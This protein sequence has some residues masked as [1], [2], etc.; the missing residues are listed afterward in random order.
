MADQAL[1]E[2][3]F[4]TVREL[5]DLLRLKER[6]VYDLA[7]S[8]AVPC[9]RATGKLLFPAAEIR[10]WIAREKSGGPA[11]SAER[12]GIALG[13]HDPLLDWAILESRCGLATY[14]DGS[15]DGLDRFVK[16]EG[17]LTGLHIFDAKSASWNVPAVAQAAAGQAAVLVSFVKR[18]RGLILR[19]DGPHPETLAELAGL[20]VA[21]R[22]DGSGT[23]GLLHA[24]AAEHG[25]DLAAVTFTDTARTEDEAA[26]SVRRGDADTTLG[27]ETVAM[28]F[29]L[30]FVPLIE[31]EFSL[32]V[33]R[34]AWFEP[35][36]QSLLAFIKTD[37]FAQRVEKSGGYETN[38]IG[39]VL[40]N[41]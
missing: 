12:P 26:Q 18:S 3:E 22:Q 38:D 37:R 34:K 35:A 27:L 30:T 28:A 11:Q 32:L 1:D 23:A 9:S 41:G 20:R 17:I 36:F 8:G 16:G 29:G 24:L 31:E 5:A 14:F 39:A 7:A 21:P 40:W 15:Q 2:R 19:P 13:S 25:L 33:D 6:K 10:Q 4:L